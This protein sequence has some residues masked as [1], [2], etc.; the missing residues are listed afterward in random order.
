MKNRKALAVG[1]IAVVAIPLSTSQMAS[2]AKKTTKKAKKT[3]VKAAK[4]VELR[5][6]TRPDNQAEID[7]YN[8]IS[9]TVDGKLAN[10]TLKYEAGTSEGSPYQDKLRTEIAAGTAPD[11]FWIPG[12]DIA[13]FAKKGLI[14]DVRSYAAKTAGY[15]DKN[16]YAGPMQSLTYNPAKKDQSSLWGLPR[17]VS[18]FAMYLNL[19]LIAK[20][21]APDP[22]QLAK[23][24]KWNWETM[25]DVAK[26][27]TE[28]GGANKGVGL[29]S[30]WANYGYFMNAAGGGFFNETRTACAADSDA[31]VKGLQFLSDLVNVDKTTVAWGEDAEKP[32]NAGNL[33]MFVN[34]RWATPGAREN[35]KFNWDVVKLPDGP[36]GPSNWLFWGAY[37]VNA[38]TKN[39]AQAWALVDAL[40][41]DD[42]Q[43]SIS[44][45]G[46]NIPSRATDAAKKNFLSYTPPAN[47]Q[48]FIDG[49]SE[50]PV[51]E[52]P[53]WNGDW[54]AYDKVLNDAVT[55][56]LT[57]KKSIADYKATICKDQAKNFN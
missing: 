43:A 7:V 50:K 53:L 27:V 40:T 16:F 57:G 13:D 4:S 29:N 12:T 11:V 47:A 42:V 41:Q 37:V 6:R 46:A 34:G 48:A 9:K 19:D 21:G 33:G 52:G 23:E 35:L 5:W 26:K 45:L 14:L 31:S 24:G 2:A 49:I 1:L 55:A 36:G 51:A 20:A 38:K 10:I 30:W 54:P 25:R 18:A 22:R 56:L 32:F 28:T 44:K 15:A 39:P 3:T 8:G 17:D